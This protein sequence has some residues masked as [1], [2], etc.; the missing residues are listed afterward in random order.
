G[1]VGWKRGGLRIQPWI[2]RP[3]WLEE[4]Q[5]SSDSARARWLN[6]PSFRRVSRCGVRAAGSATATSAGWPGR[7]CVN[8]ILPPPSENDPLA[9]G[10]PSVVPP[11]FPATVVHSLSSDT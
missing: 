1:L 6:K 9:Y 8:A 4:Y 5:I 3:S 11:T 10:R 7:V 2:L